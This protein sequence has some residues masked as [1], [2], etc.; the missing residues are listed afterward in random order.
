MIQTVKFG[1]VFVLDDKEYVFLAK[2]DDVVYAVEILNK[3][4]S[5]EVTRLASR[6][7]RRGDRSV[8]KLVFCFVELSTERF[9]ERV[10]HLAKAGRGEANI[11]FDEVEDCLSAEDKDAIKKE[12]VDNSRF[13]AT[14][15]IETVSKIQ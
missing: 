1:N 14:E 15:L 9:K 10:A 12:L 3:D 13:F 8:D 7:A 5:R 11:E 4:Y 6:E 2:I